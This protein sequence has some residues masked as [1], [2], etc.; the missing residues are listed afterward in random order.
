MAS[1]GILV[2]QAFSILSDG[3]FLALVL[4]A[5]LLWRRYS[6]TSSN[7]TL[8]ACCV[9]VAIAPLVRFHGLFLCAALGVG[10]LYNAYCAKGIDAR[11]LTRAAAVCLLVILPFALWTWRNWA[12]HTPETFSMASFSSG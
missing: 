2:R 11:S 12:L 9:V 1:A 6:E 10:L 5:L 3:L 7:R 8:V 4:S